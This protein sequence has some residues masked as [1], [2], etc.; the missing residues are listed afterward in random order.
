MFAERFVLSDIVKHFT[1][2]NVEQNRN[3]IAENHENRWNRRIRW[4][5]LS[6]TVNNNIHLHQYY[7]SVTVIVG[8][9]DSGNSG[10]SSS[11]SN[12]KHSKSTRSNSSTN[13]ATNYKTNYNN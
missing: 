2:T 4:N 11:C 5:R 10:N 3:K 12:D 8:S 6:T 9:V 7:H 1:L 13:I